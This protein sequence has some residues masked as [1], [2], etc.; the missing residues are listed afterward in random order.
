MHRS[1]EFFPDSF[2]HHLLSLDC[3]LSFKLVRH[4]LDRNVRAVWVVK[5]TWENKRYLFVREKD[6]V[7]KKLVH[8]LVT[9]SHRLTTASLYLEAVF[10]RRN[11]TCDF[12]SVRSHGILNLLQTSRHDARIGTRPGAHGSGHGKHARLEGGPHSVGGECS[13]YRRKH[14]DKEREGNQL[15]RR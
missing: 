4:Y 10:I 13:S 6:T 8:F 2:V 1:L 5:C 9:T 14:D 3:S 11:R 12:N 7:T 15:H